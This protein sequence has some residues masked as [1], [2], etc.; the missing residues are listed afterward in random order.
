MRH[1]GEIDDE[2]C[3]VLTL[4]LSPIWRIPVEMPL[5]L[6]NEFR[7]D[8]QSCLSKFDMTPGYIQCCCQYNITQFT[9]YTQD[10]Q[11]CCTFNALDKIPEETQLRVLYCNR[12]HT[13]PYFKLIIIVLEKFLSMFVI[14]KTTTATTIS[15]TNLWRKDHWRCDDDDLMTVDS[16]QIGCHI[17]AGNFKFING[18]EQRQKNLV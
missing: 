12:K 3:I 5:S 7:T 6:A 17:F 11:H 18:T 13:K 1:C 14:T 16:R 10:T 8:E 2:L 15:T 4:W 9:D